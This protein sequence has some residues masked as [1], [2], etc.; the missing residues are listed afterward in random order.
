MEAPLDEDNDASSPSPG[1]NA[2][3]RKLRR[4]TRSC[5]DCKKRKVKCTFESTT[6]TVC[7]ACRRRGA[8]CVGQENPDEKSG[9]EDGLDQLFDRVV[10]VKTLLEELV[11]KLGQ[12]VQKDGNSTGFDRAGRLKSGAVTPFSDFQSTN[13]FA[14]S[15]R[16]PESTYKAWWSFL[17][18]YELLDFH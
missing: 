2:K 15:V 14:L 16:V 18:P 1:P 13:P 6:D 7:I 9:A 8:A 12:C 5:W 17:W 10:G 11:D 3:R 4:G